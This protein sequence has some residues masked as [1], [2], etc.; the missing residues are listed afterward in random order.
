[1]SHKISG[2]SR[3]VLLESARTVPSVTQYAILKTLLSIDERLEEI[4]LQQWH[5]ANERRERG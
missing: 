1:M 5:D 4:A 2:D 3:K